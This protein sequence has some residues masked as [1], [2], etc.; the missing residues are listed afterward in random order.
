MITDTPDES[1]SKYTPDESGCKYTPDESGGRDTPDES[2]LEF[3]ENVRP[4]PSALSADV[5]KPNRL[6]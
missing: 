1:E 6:K 2:Q 5:N 4:K 3:E